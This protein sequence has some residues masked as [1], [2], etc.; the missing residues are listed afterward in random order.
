MLARDHMGRGTWLSHPRPSP[1]TAYWSTP[2]WASADHGDRWPHPM[3]NT[4]S[5]FGSYLRRIKERCLSCHFPIISINIWLLISRIESVWEM[6]EGNRK[7]VFLWHISWV[8]SV[9]RNGWIIQRDLDSISCPKTHN[10]WH[11]DVVCWH[12]STQ[13]YLIIFFF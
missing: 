10:A 1:P 9:Y 5:Q 3:T 12:V 13:Y 11:V 7:I 4:R 6:T 8:R 2:G